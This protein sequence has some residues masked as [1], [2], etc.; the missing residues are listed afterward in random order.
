MR[1]SGFT[2]VELLVSIAI[3]AIVLSIGIPSFNELTRN[4][5]M[6]SNSSDLLTA[7]NYARIESVKRGSSITLGQKD[8]STWGGGLVVWIDD[9]GDG[10]VDAGEEVLRYWEALSTGSTLVSTNSITSFVFSASGEVDNLD[11]LTLCDNRTGE[12]GRTISILL[13]GAVYVEEKV[14]P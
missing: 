3:M 1:N 13:S 14:C 11:T 9:D 6:S 7:F 12:T 10:T 4:S 8:S 2:V 5:A